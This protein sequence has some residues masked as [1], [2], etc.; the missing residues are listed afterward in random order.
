MADTRPSRH[1]SWREVASKDGAPYPMKWRSTRLVQLLRLAEE[2]RERCGGLPLTVSSAYRSPAHNRRIGGARHSQHVEGLA[3]DLKPPKGWSVTRFHA[4]I[5]TFAR[6]R[7]LGKYRTF[8]HV[9]IR[10]TSRRV[11][12]SGTGKKD[13]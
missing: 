10:E 4:L 6:V 7:G 13:S 1:F 3:L 9:D 12:W 8:V 5:K 2:I 11:S